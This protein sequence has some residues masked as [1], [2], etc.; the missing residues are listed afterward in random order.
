MTRPG[1]EPGPPRLEA[2]VGVLISLWLFLFATQT[3]EFFFYML[4]KLEQRSHKCVDLR[5]ECVE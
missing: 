1:F 4:K 3:K 5:G 2:G